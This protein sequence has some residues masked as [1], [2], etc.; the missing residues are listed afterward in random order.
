VDKV[1]SYG[2]DEK[3][4]MQRP[5]SSNSPWRSGIATQHLALSY[6]RVQILRFSGTV[7][8]KSRALHLPAFE[9]CASLGQ[10]KRTEYL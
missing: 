9:A 4:L 3:V 5:L 1:L 6:K 2:V 8:K 7:L 10:D